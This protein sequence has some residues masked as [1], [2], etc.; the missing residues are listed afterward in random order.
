M[1]APYLVPKKSTDAMVEIDDEMHNF[2]GGQGHYDV[3]RTM[4]KSTSSPD[5]KHHPKPKP[6]HKPPLRAATVD[7]DPPYANKAAIISQ[8]SHLQSDSSDLSTLVVSPTHPDDYI[9]TGHNG[10]NYQNLNNDQYECAEDWLGGKDKNGTGELVIQP[11]SRADAFAKT[12]FNPPPVHDHS[13]SHAA[14]FPARSHHI[15]TTS[16]PLSSDIRYP[17]P[18]ITEAPLQ[19]ISPGNEYDAL[20]LEE[21]RH[22][23]LP[24]VTRQLV[25]RRNSD[26]PVIMRRKTDHRRGSDTPPTT[27]KTAGPYD[28][29]IASIRKTLPQAS[30]AICVQ[31]LNKN[32]GDMDRTLE[33][34]KVHILMDMGLDNTNAEQ[35]RKALSHC[36]WKLD[37]AAEWLIE[38][39][40]S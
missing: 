23:T 33:D 3:P 30:D 31:Y 1:P 26:S 9:A 14:T 20:R 16:P 12:S 22:T 13:A 17:P 5:V 25:D 34:V 11:S 37:R 6:R 28:H 19:G 36:Q 10:P 15:T 38:Q 29:L 35:C 40:I 32:K 8:Y 7:N 24:P 4:S 18:M 2:S 39:S 21:R 27:R